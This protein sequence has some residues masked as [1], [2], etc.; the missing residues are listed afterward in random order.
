MQQFEDLLAA[1][2][3]DAAYALLEGSDVNRQEYVLSIS[4]WNALKQSV[5]RGLTSVG[6]KYYDLSL[7]N[8]KYG[9]TEIAKGVRKWPEVVAAPSEEQPTANKVA[10][11]RKVFLSVENDLADQSFDKN[12]V[13]KYVASL[14][15]A[16]ESNAYGA[17][18]DTLNGSEWNALNSAEQRK[19]VETALKNLLRYKDR[20][21]E[22][23]GEYQSKVN[24]TVPLDESVQTFFNNPSL[25]SW[26]ELSGQLDTRFSDSSLFS[27]AVYSAF[28]IW[29][30]KINGI[31][32]ELMFAMDFNFDHKRDFGA[33]LNTNLQI[34]N[35]NY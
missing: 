13:E 1:N 29:K 23:I 35:F 7:A 20:I 33:F 22:K 11:V 9:M 14:N 26:N 17:F 4:Q 25:K 18:L 32:D 5:R 15:E 19:R 34:K 31:T 16:F 10:L 24:N 3:L 21:M 6:D 2:D 12:M 28:Q 8:I 30:E 27:P